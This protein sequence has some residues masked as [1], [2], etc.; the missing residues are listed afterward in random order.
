MT[1]SRSPAG[2]QRTLPVGLG[3]A[4]GRVSRERSSRSGVL[5]DVRLSLALLL[6]NLVVEPCTATFV[7]IATRH[8]QP[9]AR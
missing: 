2:S 8:E 9:L 3:G 7:A 1:W 4:T 5:L 6:V